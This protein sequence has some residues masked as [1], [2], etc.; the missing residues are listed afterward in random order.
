MCFSLAHIVH[1][2]SLQVSDTTP[3]LTF[4]HHF[5]L[6]LGCM[7]LEPAQIRRR[8]A[9]DF[10]G[11]YDHVCAS[12]GSAPVRAV[13]ASLS[14]GMLDFNPDPISLADWTPILSAL[15]I[16]KHLQHVAIKSSYLT[17]SGAQS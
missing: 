13:K 7:M 14:R 16:N 3:D 11:F 1:K 12:Q 4:F 2:S 8:G 5:H 6:D 17:S 10:E 9:Q 15:A